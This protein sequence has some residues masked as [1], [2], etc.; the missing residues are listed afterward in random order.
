MQIKK[1]YILRINGLLLKKIKKII[2][3]SSISNTPHTR[4]RA[5]FLC[6]Q[7]IVFL[8]F[9]NLH[10]SLSESVQHIRQQWK[11]KKS[12]AVN[13]FD[14]PFQRAESHIIY[15]FLKTREVNENRIC[16]Q[17][18]VARAHSKQAGQLELNNSNNNKVFSKCS[19]IFMCLCNSLSDKSVLRTEN[20]ERNASKKKE[21]E[22]S[23]AKFPLILFHCKALN[24]S[25]PRS[26]N[27]TINISFSLFLS[28]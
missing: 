10:C 25:T 28:T 22:E 7:Q 26:I 21:R 13:L 11:R 18:S 5:A 27:F 6:Q 9:S 17:L 20:I 14:N 12:G 1:H 4:L 8:P 23:A 19:L 2:K 24:I 16:S 3:I 15:C